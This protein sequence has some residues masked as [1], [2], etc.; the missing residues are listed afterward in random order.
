MGGRRGSLG[1]S[2]E[3]TGE[4]S[5]S[6]VQMGIPAREELWGG[7]KASLIFEAKITMHHLCDLSQAMRKLGTL[8]PSSAQ[9]SQSRV[10][11]CEWE[12]GAAHCPPN[13]PLA[14]MARWAPSTGAPQACS[15][16]WEVGGS[17]GLYF[18]WHLKRCYGQGGRARKRGGWEAKEKPGS[19]GR[20]KILSVTRRG[21]GFAGSLM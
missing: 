14:R 10:S 12:G 17:A 19:D 7:R 21:G 6:T 13:C 4:F 5:S 16:T 18:P 15:Q 11:E 20:C 3:G 8:A 1:D 2:R 9:H